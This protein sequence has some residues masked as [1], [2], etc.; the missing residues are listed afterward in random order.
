MAGYKFGLSEIQW[1]ENSET[2]I[3]NGNFLIFSGVGEDTEHRNG[4]CILMNKEA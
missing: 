4:V 3:Q 2:K 1:K